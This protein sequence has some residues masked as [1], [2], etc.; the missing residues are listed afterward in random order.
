MN[1]AAADLKSADIACGIYFTEGGDAYW[2]KYAE[3]AFRSIIPEN[4][5]SLFVFEKISSMSEV[6]DAA[7]TLSF[8]GDVNVVVV[9]DGDYKPTEGERA[10]LLDLDAEDCYILFLSPKFFGA[11]EKK[12]FNAIDCGKSDKFR[13]ARYAERLFPS[14]IE[15]D[16]LNRLAEYTDCD[17]AKI[18][19]EAAKLNA[20]CGDRRVT[21]SDV[22][23]TVTEDAEIQVFAFVTNL[24]E[25]RNELALKQ[26]AR[27]IKRGESPSYLLATITGQYRR[28]LYA[29]LSDKSDAELASVMRV[30]EYAVKKARSVR[31]MTKKQLRDTVN[32]LSAYELKFKSG[33]MSE[34]TAFDAA[35]SR[36]ISK[37]VK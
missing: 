28:M 33:E 19:N 20:F 14:G 32:M 24:T 30:K 10:A 4:S 37:E 3:N 11:A 36:L 15:K 26:I 16:A 7:A 13:C 35:I 5:L 27:L 22:E 2:Q 23:E 6:F 21:L 8:S 31:T 1:I 17:M 18:D 29:V 12:R 34:R 25:G 9:R